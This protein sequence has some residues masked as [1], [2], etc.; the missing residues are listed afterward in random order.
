MH[1]KILRVLVNM[2]EY[3]LI[4]V[5][6]FFQAILIVFM[7]DYIINSKFMGAII[8]L[9]GYTCISLMTRQIIIYSYTS[10]K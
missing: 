9:A 4:L 1:S 2:M 5:M 3:I 10:K 8:G 6:Q 7:V